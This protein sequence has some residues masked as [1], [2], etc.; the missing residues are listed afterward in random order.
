[1]KARYVYV[2]CGGQGT[3][4]ALPYSG[5]YRVLLR[6]GEK[7]FKIAVGDREKI[8]TADQVWPHMGDGP[9]QTD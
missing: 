1:M 9:L 6:P 4:P 7:V 8:V 2:R 3:P 5:P